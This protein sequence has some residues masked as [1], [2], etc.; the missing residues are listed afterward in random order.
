MEDEVVVVHLFSDD[1]VTYVEISNVL[2]LT[3]VTKK[4]NHESQYPTTSK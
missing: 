2:L 3:N 1:V 4:K